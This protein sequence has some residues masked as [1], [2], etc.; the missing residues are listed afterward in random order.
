M[1]IGQVL[2]LWWQEWQELQRWV[3]S[4][5]PPQRMDVIINFKGNR[6]GALLLE[7][8]SI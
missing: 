5:R 1:L 4:R 3:L 8:P 6:D 7:Q 2:Y